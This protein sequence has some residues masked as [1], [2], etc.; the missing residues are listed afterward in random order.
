MPRPVFIHVHTVLHFDYSSSIIIVGQQLQPTIT[1]IKPIGFSI[2]F[3]HQPPKLFAWQRAPRPKFKSH[4]YVHMYFRTW[5][6]IIT[7]TSNSVHAPQMNRYLLRRIRMDDGRRHIRSNVYRGQLARL[8]FG[9]LGG[10]FW[11]GG[12]DMI[13][14]YDS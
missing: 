12:E 4:Q 11:G 5:A 7:T 3:Q 1:F 10:F 8:F 14:S 2:Q 9:F 13:D 6:V